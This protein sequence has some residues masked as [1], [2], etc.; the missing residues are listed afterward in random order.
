MGIM[1]RLLPGS[2]YLLNHRSIVRCIRQLVPRISTRSRV[3]GKR[4][5][6]QSS[7]NPFVRMPTTLPQELVDSVIDH[8]HDDPMTLRSCALV[9]NAWLPS[10]RSHIFHSITLQPPDKPTKKSFF[11]R[12][13]TDTQ[14]LLRMLQFSPEIALYVRN[15]SI[16]EGMVGREWIAQERTLPV[17]LSM[18]KNVQRFQLERS[19]SMQISWIDLPKDLKDALTGILATPTLLELSLVG[20]VFDRPA[21]LH[22]MLQACQNLRLLEANHLLLRD[23]SSL[24][25]GSPESRQRAPLDVLDVGPRT[26]TALIDCLLH[27][28]SS[29][30]VTTI[31]K[32]SIAISGNFA[33]VAKLLRSTS[34]IEALEIVLMNDVNLKEYW[35]LPPSDRFNLSDN[36]HLH[37][38]DLKIDVIQ[39]QDDPLPW[40][41]DLFLT[42]KL[43]NN[44]QYINIVYAVYLP[45]PYMERSINTMIFDEWRS[46]DVTL[47]S[48]EFGNLK[49]VKLDFMLETPLGYGVA[50]RFMKGMNLRSPL[51]EASGLLTVTA[52]NN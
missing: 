24:A 21:D 27:P 49:K 50:P 22:S 34:S 44:L 35:S 14:R 23:A 39:R 42:V 4:R 32:L 37:T 7:F 1:D 26:S 30:D 41:N 9:C 6:P 20:L 18:L 13:L 11:V 25:V 51:L 36:P 12:K 29:I 3:V 47:S 16:C 28:E 31:R 5:V 19:A 52:V 17:F 8:C 43:P 33:N 40:L 48:L 45:G 46:V 10:S 15:L 2:Y 38:L